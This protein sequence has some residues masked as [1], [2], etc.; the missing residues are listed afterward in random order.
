MP[1]GA[2]THVEFQPARFR[3]A[4]ADD[5]AERIVTPA[6]DLAF[7][8]RKGQT[9]RALSFPGVSPL[10]LAGLIPHGFFED[11]SHS[12]DL[13]CGHVVLVDRSGRQVTDLEPAAPVPGGEADEPIRVRRSFRVATAAGDIVKTYWVYRDR[14]RVDLRLEF[15]FPSIRPI[16]F[17][18]GALTAL[19]RSFDPAAIRYATANGGT[20]VETF[21]LPG[22]VVAHDAPV[23][24]LVSATS[25][26]G[27]TE[28]WLDF[29]DGDKGIGVIANKAEL[30]SAFLV[31]HEPVDDLFYFRAWA[32]VGENDETSELVWR[33]HNA[34]TLSY[35]G[36]GGD[37]APVREAARAIR[38]PLVAVR[39]WR[40]ASAD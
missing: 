27:A 17:R 19:P 31:H 28:G 16:S 4:A 22:R 21:D 26:V 1:A 29:A 10:P 13:F 15:R 39:A 23:T 8:P 14:P 33:G 32:T 12:F 7:L 18:V 24:T 11:I 2:T 25:C 37:L 3:K 35:V 30:F 20:A 9:I 6:V 40:G 34:L 5:S 36:H 38:H